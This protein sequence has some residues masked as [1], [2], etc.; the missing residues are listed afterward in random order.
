MVFTPVKVFDL[1]PCLGKEMK[2]CQGLFTFERNALI[3]HYFSHG[4]L[5]GTKL[6]QVNMIRMNG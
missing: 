6:N 4:K 2:P 3:G 5:G 1:G